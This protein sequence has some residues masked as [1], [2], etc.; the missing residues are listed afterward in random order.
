MER[1]HIF[2]K[3]LEETVEGEGKAT[4]DHHK[5]AETLFD[6]MNKELSDDFNIPGALSCLF[7]SH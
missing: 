1:I 2:V 6:K 3:N 7:F 5:R 4:N